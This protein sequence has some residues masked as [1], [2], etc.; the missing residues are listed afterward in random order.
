MQLK[1]RGRD[2]QRAGVG[3]RA[4]VPAQTPR[5]SPRTARRR[6]GCARATRAYASL[7]LKPGITMRFEPLKVSTTRLS[8]RCKFVQN[9]LLR[10]LILHA[11]PLVG[12]AWLGHS[13]ETP[14]N[15]PSVGLGSA[16]WRPL[17]HW[18]PRQ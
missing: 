4:R 13:P 5:R 14:D 6:S 7:L 10:L 2:G 12:Y 9:L 15:R 18:F 17:M 3:A 1:G 11:V 16:R 8:M